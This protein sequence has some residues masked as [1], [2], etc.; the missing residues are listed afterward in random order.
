[1]CSSKA[2]THWHHIPLFKVNRFVF[3]S[4]FNPRSFN[5]DNAAEP[6]PGPWFEEE[7]KKYCF[8]IGCSCR[9]QLCVRF[10]AWSVSLPVCR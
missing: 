4:S 2:L 10:C 8:V 1:M 3:E 7:R 9:A 6:G 5:N